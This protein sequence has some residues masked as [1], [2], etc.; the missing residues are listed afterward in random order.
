M[1]G[2]VERGREKACTRANT[3][4]LGRLVSPPAILRGQTYRGR[5]PGMC[6]LCQWIERVISTVFWA[7][8]PCVCSYKHNLRRVICIDGTYLSGNF[9]GTLLV[10]YVAD[11]GNYTFP[12]PFMV[13]EPEIEIVGPGPYSNALCDNWYGPRPRYYLL[14]AERFYGLRPVCLT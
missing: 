12:V 6:M 9:F 1:S 13:V 5:S 3:W 8:G 14:K 10:T 2:I 4:L 7:I 11:A